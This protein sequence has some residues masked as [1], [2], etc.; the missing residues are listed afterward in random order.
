[1]AAISLSSNNTISDAD[2]EKHFSGWAGPPGKTEQNRCENAISAIKNAI[3][4]SAKLKSRRIKVFTQGSY[5]NRV[6][7][8]QDS[9]VDIGVLCPDTYYFRLPSGKTESQVG[10]TDG[11]AEYQYADFKNDLEEALV[12]YFGRSAVARGNKALKVHETSYHVDADVVPVFEFR[13]YSESGWYYAGVAL[14]PDKGGRIENFP[15][16][17]RDDWPNTP[18]HYENGVNKN[19]ATGRRYKS[20]VRIIKKLRHIL[21][22]SGS[23]EAKTIPGYLIES[24]VWNVDDSNFNGKSWLEIVRSVLLAIWSA[25]E[26]DDSCKDWCEVDDIKFLF[27]P[28][29]PWTREQARAFTLK[30]WSLIGIK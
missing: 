3:G 21:D 23:S 6:N 29:Q 1:M 16:R 19:T 12:N 18:L 15:E 8:R 24:M 4:R 5:R 22:E 2:W 20:V 11:P 30:A 7:I 25:T 10:I 27:R 26:S 14:R 9:D 13:S 28:A 17:L